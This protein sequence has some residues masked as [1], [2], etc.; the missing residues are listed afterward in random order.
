MS[1]TKTTTGLTTHSQI[2]ARSQSNLDWN[3]R[4]KP[5]VTPRREY[6]FMAQY[7]AIWMHHAGG[8]FPP[9]NGGVSQ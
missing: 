2:P 6:A 4:P 9:F 7:G 3:T 1:K 8:S 5:A